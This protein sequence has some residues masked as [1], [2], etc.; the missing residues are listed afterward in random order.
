MALNRDM[1]MAELDRRL[2]NVVRIG[3]VAEADYPAARVRVAIGDN[4]T[5]GLPWL[6][7]RAGG[8]RA[9]WAPEVGEQVMV[10][11]PGGDLAQG[12]VLPALFSNAAPAP[13][14]S[15]DIRREVYADGLVIEH[16]R[17]KKLTRLNALDSEGTLVLEAKN[18]VIRTG[19]GGYYQLDH[20]G[21]ASRITHVGGAAF[22]TD[23][24][25]AGAVV[26]ANAD[27]D[28]SPPEVQTP[29]ES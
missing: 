2:A 26:T 3:T 19:D 21:M 8:D 13:A 28:Y 12:V 11:S 24:W 22:E 17:A 23:S 7:A 25:Q 9:W 18:I 4:L 1:E 27:Q 6:T 14:D 29:E 5:G 16:D 20:H 10:F 15:P